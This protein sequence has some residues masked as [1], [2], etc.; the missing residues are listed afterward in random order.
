VA[1]E[2]EVMEIFEVLLSDNGIYINCSVK[3]MRTNG[4]VVNYVLINVGNLRSLVQT[5]QVSKFP[6]TMLRLWEQLTK[7]GMMAA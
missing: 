4:V 5:W 7:I 3:I 1:L 6:M 2:I